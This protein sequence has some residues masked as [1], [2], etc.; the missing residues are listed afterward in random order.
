MNQ[1]LFQGTGQE[2]GGMWGHLLRVMLTKR[3]GTSFSRFRVDLSSTAGFIILTQPLLP[4]FSGYAFNRAKDSEEALLPILGNDLL[5]DEAR[6]IGF[7]CSDHRCG[8]LARLKI[9]APPRR[10]EVRL[11]HGQLFPENRPVDRDSPMGND[12]PN[13]KEVSTVQVLSFKK[14]SLFVDRISS[15][16]SARGCCSC[17]AAGAAHRPLTPPLGANS[18]KQIDHAP[19]L[20]LSEAFQ[21]PAERQIAPAVFPGENE[22][23]FVG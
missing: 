7:Q 5:G 3:T 8:R 2:H 16:V 22:Q 23:G 18:S 9:I 14:C 15:T 20:D 4:Q 1:T 10:G 13:V 17:M 19:V 6:Q 21:I 11:I 12:P